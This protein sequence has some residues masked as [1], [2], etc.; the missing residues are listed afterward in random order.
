MALSPRNQIMRVRQ[1]RVAVDDNAQWLFRL[2][3][4]EPHV[5]SG[6]IGKGRATADQDGIVPRPLTVNVTA[7]QRSRHPAA[8]PICTSNAPIEAGG[9]LQGHERTPYLPGKEESG[10]QVL[11]RLAASPLFHFNTRLPQPRQTSPVDAQ[12]RIAQGDDTAGDP[13][14]DQRIRTR[15]RLPMMGARFERDIGC[16]ALRGLA[17][18]AQG[19]GLCVRTAT[20]LSPA[21]ADDPAVLDDQTADGGIG[22]DPAEPSGGK[23]Q[24][25]LHEAAIGEITPHRR[26]CRRILRNREPPGSSGRR[27]RN[28]HKPPCRARPGHPSPVRQ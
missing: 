25:G 4:G 18:L 26:A 22:R 20:R 3:P 10:I 24:C 2:Q 27:R 14:P 11:R 28:A 9:K 21:T 7:C 1:A 17:R 19:L 23:R 12:V 13:G 15:R 16:G 5:Q 8:V 6:I